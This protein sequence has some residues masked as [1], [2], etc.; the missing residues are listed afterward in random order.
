ML[1]M[2]VLVTAMA[3]VLGL[4]FSVNTLVLLTVAILIM[5]GIS[6]LG[7]SSPLVI[8]FQ[9]MATLASVQISYLFGSLLAAHFHARARTPSDRAQ[10]RH[11]L[12]RRLRRLVKRPGKVLWLGRCLPP[13]ARGWFFSASET[14]PSRAAVW[15]TASPVEWSHGFIAPKFCSFSPYDVGAGMGQY[16][17]HFVS[18]KSR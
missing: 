8:A 10:M 17:V 9:I 2:G 15:V 7:R 1:A 16:S 13:V 14:L 5:F 18:V 6:I 4:R 12:G 3:L 11:T